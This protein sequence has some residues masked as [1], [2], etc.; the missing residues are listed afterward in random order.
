MPQPKPLL[1]LT[2]SLCLSVSLSPCTLATA[3]YSGKPLVTA[4]T[5]DPATSLYTSPLK[6][7]RPLVLDLSGPL[8]WS[9]CERS[10]PTLECHHHECAHAHS[11]HPPNCPHSGYGVA[12]EEDRFRCKCTAHPYNPFTGKSARGDLTRVRLSANATDGKNPLYPVSFSAVAS[13]APASLLAKLP[14]GAAGVAGLANTRLALPAQVARTQ[15]VSKK[16]VLCLPRTGDGVAIFGGG[17][18]F[19]LSPSQ[20]GDL[21]STLTYTQFLIKKNNPA[22]HLPVKGIAVNKAQVQFPGHALANGGIVLGTRVPYT[23]LRS[24]VYRPLVDAFDKALGR[25]DAKVPAVAPFELCYDSNKLGPTRIGFLVPDI[26]LMLEGGKNWTFSGSNSMVD[27]DNF[28][29]ACFAFVEM[30]AEKG[31]YGGA[32]AVVIGGFQMENHVLQ[33]DLEKQQLGFAKLLFFTSCGN[34]NFTRSL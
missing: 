34:F 12:D 19:L 21:T 30:K 14:A 4:V 23:E 6:D 3:S 5:K 32:P 8:I 33:F 31:G 24:D 17:P 9:T 15:K 28:R 18:F 27:V 16:F 13:C 10:H 22:Y 20:L 7:S 2:I 29:K 1:L 25:D 11:F 26:V